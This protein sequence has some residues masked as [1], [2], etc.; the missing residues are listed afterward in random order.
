[1]KFMKFEN[2]TFIC[3]CGRIIENGRKYGLK[4]EKRFSNEKRKEK[5]HE[6]ICE[7]CFNALNLKNSRQS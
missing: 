6:S 7:Y 5:I 3:K 4:P 2:Q 1:M